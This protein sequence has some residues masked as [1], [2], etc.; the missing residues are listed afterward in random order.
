MMPCAAALL[1]SDKNGAV[2]PK[3]MREACSGQHPTANEAAAHRRE[4][5]TAM[6]IAAAR[7]AAR[8]DVGELLSRARDIANLVRARA[9]PTERDRRISD[10][11][12]ERM[13]QAELFK[14]LQPQ[15]YGGFEYN[16]D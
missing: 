10:D 6:S 7:T 9:Q 12:I 5:I 4:C 14:I 11:V 15:A 3:L 1:S 16:F 2:R 8:P 13:R